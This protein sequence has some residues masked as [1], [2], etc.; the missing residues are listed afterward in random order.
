MWPSQTSPTVGRHG[1]A[2]RQQRLATGSAPGFSGG[3]AQYHSLALDGQSIP[4]LAYLD[5][6]AENK[7]TVMRFYGSAWQVVLTPV[8]SAVEAYGTSLAL[9]EQRIPYVAYSDGRNWG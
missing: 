9:D 3:Y 4:Y 1:D 7:A 5:G 6:A 8:F 2:L